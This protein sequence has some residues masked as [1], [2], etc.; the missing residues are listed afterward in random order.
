MWQGIKTL[1]G[2]KDSYTATTPTDNTLP[3]T[4]NHLVLIAGTESQ[5]LIH[6]E[7]STNSTKNAIS[8]LLLI[9]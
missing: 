1:T 5:A 4:L 8:G 2:Y 7:P 3:D 9:I 6:H